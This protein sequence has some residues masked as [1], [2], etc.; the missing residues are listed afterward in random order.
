MTTSATTS[1]LIRVRLTRATLTGEIGRH[2]P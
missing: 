1:V 2:P